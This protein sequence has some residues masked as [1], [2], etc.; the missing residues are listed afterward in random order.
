MKAVEFI[1]KFG[2]AIAVKSVNH[3]MNAYNGLGDSLY[4][5][6]D[7]YA[8]IIHPSYLNGNECLAS[9]LKQYVDA[10][11]LV[12]KLGGL[13]GAKGE[14][15]EIAHS[16]SYVDVSP[17]E[18]SKAIQLV[19]SVENKDDLTDHCTNI[20]NHVSPLTKVIDK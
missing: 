19:E 4:C 18:L 10:W 16:G 7:G 3:A 8:A 9:D 11:E 17:S 12:N 14:F 20:K 13:D 1:R 5:R 15:F 2:W 6:P